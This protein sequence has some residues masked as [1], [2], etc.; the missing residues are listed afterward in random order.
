MSTPMLAWY[1]RASLDGAAAHLR[2]DPVLE[3]AADLTFRDADGTWWRPQQ[4]G[5]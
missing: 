5:S 2:L 3:I 4:D 1:P